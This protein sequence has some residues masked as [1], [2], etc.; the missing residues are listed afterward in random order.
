M[1]EKGG[2]SFSRY[3]HLSRI[4]LVLTTPTC[5]SDGIMKGDKFTRKGGIPSHV[6]SCR[7][8]IFYST[9]RVPT[10]LLLRKWSQFSQVL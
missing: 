1:K 5:A 8:C 2:G 9:Q 6:T 7:R 10:L 4:N 3:E